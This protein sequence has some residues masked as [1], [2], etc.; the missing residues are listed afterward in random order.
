MQ[1]LVHSYG[2]RL[3]APGGERLGRPGRDFD[4]RVV[5]AAPAAARRRSSAS[6]SKVWRAGDPARARQAL[7]A[8]SS[9]SSSGSGSASASGSSTTA[10]TAAAAITGSRSPRRLG[11]AR[12]DLGAPLAVGHDRARRGGGDDR[13][14][15]VVVLR[16]RLGDL[17]LLDHDCGRCRRERLAASMAD[18]S[19]RLGYDGLGLRLG[20]DRRRGREHRIAT[21]A[22]LRRIV[23]LRGLGRGGRCRERDGLEV[24][25]NSLVGFL[26]DR[27]HHL[28]LVRRRGDGSASE[29]GSGSTATSGATASGSS[30]TSG[31][32]PRRPPRPPRPGP[33][34]RRAPSP[35]RSG[36]ARST[37]PGGTPRPPRNSRSTTIVSSPGRRRRQRAAR[38]VDRPVGERL[39]AHRGRRD[40]RRLV[41]RARRGI[42]RAQLLQL[43]RRR[44]R[45]LRDVVARRQ[46]RGRSAAA[47]ASRPTRR[48]RRRSSRAASPR[49]S[50]ADR[51]RP[52]RARP[53]ARRG[54]APRPGTEA[55][56]V[57]AL[58]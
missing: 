1:Q 32:T 24:V 13:P 6:G 38:R 19:L 3:A 41:V 22:V 28:G 45:D 46:A 7:G 51:D 31:S 50:R 25:E 15:A 14:S 40:P 26:D 4:P 47:R 33:H 23:R 44:Q 12:L 58:L 29:L 57:P 43:P 49:R 18:V 9:V 42:A 52:P 20:H 30:T 55:R 21:V 8:L 48:T 53:P 16:L 27:L 39:G 17:L 10:P 5:A 36:R 35:P 34:P 2:S 56:D 11:S 37:C 54:R